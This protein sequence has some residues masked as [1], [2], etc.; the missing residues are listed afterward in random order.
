RNHHQ[1]VRA[2]AVDDDAF[3]FDRVG[4]LRFRLPDAVL[5]VHLHDV[6]VGADVAINV[7]RQLA[8]GCVVPHQLNQFVYTVDLGFETRRIGFHN[9]L[10]GGATIRGRHMDHG[11]TNR[12]ILRNGQAFEGNQPDD[13]RQ[14]GDDHGYDW[15]PYEE[16]S[17]DLALLFLLTRFSLLR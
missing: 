9:R 11:G 8:V 7:Q 4:Q 14:D 15:P 12:R 1:N 2:G 6:H 13:P 16:V 10:R 3:F 5:R 17:H